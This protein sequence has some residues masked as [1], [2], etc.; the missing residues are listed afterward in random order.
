VNRRAPLL[1]RVIGTPGWQRVVAAQRRYDRAEGDI[2]AAGISYF[3]IFAIFPL[4]MVGFAAAGFVLA[5]RPAL[6]AEIDSRVKAA[7]PGDFSEQL[8]SLIDAAIDSRASVGVI[9]LVSALYVGLLWVQR[10]RA[11]LTQMWQQ[12]CAATDFVR[13]KLSDLRALL[14][15]LLASVL[16]V[17]LTVLADPIG[18]LAGPWRLVSLA[19]SVLVSWALFTLMI[20]RLPRRPVDVRR[21]AR[22][23]LIAAVGFEVFK[24][25]AS[26]YLRIVMHGPAG[27]TFGPVL[28]LLVFVYITARLVL[29]AACWAAERSDATA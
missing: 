23:G 14:A 19:G 28:G 8:I 18:A 1:T 27:A 7:V 29:F 15:I 20:A 17:G 21:C 12:D 2:Y 4:L 10:L 22:A 6:L 13:T 24:Q 16:T 25:V 9:G 11:A 3:T 26:I 5:G